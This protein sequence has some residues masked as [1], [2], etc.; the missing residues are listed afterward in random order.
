ME[1]LRLSL[2][3]SFNR[4]DDTHTLEPVEKNGMTPQTSLQFYLFI[5]LIIKVF[6]RQVKKKESFKSE[7]ESTRKNTT[8]AH[9]CAD[10][11]LRQHTHTHTFSSAYKETTYLT[12]C[13]HRHIR[14][15]LK[16]HRHTFKDD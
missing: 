11:E 14:N 16:T 12:L 1:G 5:F 3:G 7:H 13:I 8:N 10:I 4:L 15:T 9:L 2:S 6:A